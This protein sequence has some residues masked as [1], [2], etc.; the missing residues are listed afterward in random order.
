MDSD[1]TSPN[2]SAV[3]R[4]VACILCL[5][6]YS[7]YAMA[8]ILKAMT[9]SGVFSNAGVFGNFLAAWGCLLSIAGIWILRRSHWALRFPMY[10]ALLFWLIIGYTVWSGFLLR[11]WYRP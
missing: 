5:V 11:S 8:G 9:P 6:G 3:T 7:W 2:P 1:P 4:A 10:L